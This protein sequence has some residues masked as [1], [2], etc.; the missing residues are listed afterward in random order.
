MSLLA[1]ELKR[2][3][4]LVATLKTKKVITPISDVINLNRFSL[5]SEKLAT[6]RFFFVE[7]KILFKNKNWIACFFEER[8]N[9]KYRKNVESFALI[10]R[11]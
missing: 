5:I 6:L 4:H 1:N 9:L 8:V 10:A 11:L 7:K 3:N 2:C